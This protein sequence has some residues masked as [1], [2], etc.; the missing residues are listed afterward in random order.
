[1]AFFVSFSCQ[2]KLQS[3]RSGKDLFPG[4]ALW[5]IIPKLHV[6]IGWELIEATRMPRP[7]TFD[8]RPRTVKAPSWTLTNSAPV[9]LMSVDARAIT[10]SCEKSRIVGM[11]HPL[12]CKKN[13]CRPQSSSSGQLGVEGRKSPKFDSPVCRFKP[14]V[15]SLLAAIFHSGSASH[16]YPVTR[17]CDFW[18]EILDD[19]K[20]CA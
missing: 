18:L 1:M 11:V 2:E 16:T 4:E 10:I 20:I 14:E 12:A 17:L 8:K 13:F 6:T 3:F 19:G 15:A 7:W 9:L 5:P